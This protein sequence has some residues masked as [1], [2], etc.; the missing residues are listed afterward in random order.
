MEMRALFRHNR[1]RRAIAFSNE[2]V[3]PPIRTNT[4]SQT[5]PQL[6]AGFCSV[7]IRARKLAGIGGRE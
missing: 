4:S 2:K 1:A 6:T 5:A 7:G 3:Q